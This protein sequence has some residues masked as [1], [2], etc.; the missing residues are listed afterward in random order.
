MVRLLAD[1]MADHHIVKTV[2][3][4]HPGPMTYLWE[5]E[6]GRVEPLLDGD[7]CDP[8]AAAFQVPAGTFYGVNRGYW[9]TTKTTEV[10]QGRSFS[11]YFHELSDSIE[12]I[13]ID[14]PEDL[15][16]A[17]EVIGRGLYDFGV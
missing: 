7:E 15:E 14:T 9:H 5:N 10:R 17:R 12:C 1:R 8:E 13:D 3:R 2:I 4:M 6:D 11:Y 16:V